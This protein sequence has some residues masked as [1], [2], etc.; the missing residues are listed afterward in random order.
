MQPQ[1]D[2]LFVYGTLKRGLA[3]HQHLAGAP[4]EGEAV[5]Q[6]IDLFDLGPF[7]MAVAGTGRTHGELYRVD[8]TRLAA[9]DRFEGVPRLY[10][11]VRW[12]LDDGRQ[13]WIYLGRGRQVRH[14]PRLPG[15]SWP[16]DHPNTSAAAPGEQDALVRPAPHATAAPP[17]PSP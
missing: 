15:G 4:A 12:R 13:A 10:E 3:N 11:R 5:L 9:L 1:G 8:A 7:P 17:A 2:L 14:S 16:A 6:G